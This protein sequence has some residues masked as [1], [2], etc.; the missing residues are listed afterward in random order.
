MFYYINLHLYAELLMVIIEFLKNFSVNV[1]EVCNFLNNILVD[2]LVMF[3]YLM[4][5]LNWPVFF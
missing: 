5:L 4:L 1:H 2:K 3:S